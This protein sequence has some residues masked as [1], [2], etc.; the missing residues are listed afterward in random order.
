MVKRRALHEVGL[1]QVDHQQCWFLP[2]TEPHV[3]PSVRIIRVEGGFIHFCSDAHR[4]GF[5]LHSHRFG[6]T[7]RWTLS[8][9]QQTRPEGAPIVKQLCTRA[10]HTIALASTR[11]CAPPDKQWLG[12]NHSFLF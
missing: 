1:D 2:E 5:V 12:K 9:K 8:C 4:Y 7:V 11:L 6:V 10:A 3:K